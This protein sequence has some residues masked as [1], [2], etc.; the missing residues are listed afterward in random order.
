MAGARKNGPA[1]TSYIGAENPYPPKR[2]CGCEAPAFAEDEYGDASCF[3]CGHGPRPDHAPQPAK[4][5]SGQRTHRKRKPG[6]GDTRPRAGSG[7]SIPER[8]DG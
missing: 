4:R 1:V 7:R 2:Y 3:H 5:G 6:A 8:G